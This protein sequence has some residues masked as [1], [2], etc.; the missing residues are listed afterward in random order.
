MFGAKRFF[1][2][3]T[4]VILGISIPFPRITRAQTPTQLIINYP[5]LQELDGALQLGLYFTLTDAGG[6]VVQDARIQSAR[7]QL[8]DGEIAENVPV[9]QPTT[10]FYIALVLDAS[11]SMSGAAESMRQ[12]AIRAINNAPEE[13][14]FAVVRFN[15]NID[16]LQP[17]T[18]DRNR[19]INA[20]GEVQ[21]VNK[22][23]T[24]LYDAAYTAIRMMSEAPQGRR[25]I[26]L[27]TDGQDEVLGG[28]PCSQHIFND[29]VLY[30]NQPDA[31]VPI[32]TIGLSTNEQRINVAELRSM[33]AQTGGL[34]AIGG[35]GELNT[36]F[37]DIMDALKSQ[38]LA[39]GQFYPSAGMHTA[40][41][42][43]VLED[44][45]LLSAVT[46][47]NVPRDYT[48]P[49]TPTLTPTPIRVKL[50]ILSVTA[51]IAQDRIAVEVVV[52]GEQA[53]SEYRFDFFDANTNQLL[54]RVILPAPL[55][56]PVSIPASK[57]DGKV[58]LE[59]RALDAQ[60][61]IISWPDE[62]DK[63]VDKVSYTF[64]YV[65]PTP[66]PTHAPATAIPVGVTLNSIGYDQASDTVTL[67]LE[68]NA[69]EQIAQLKVSVLD[70]ETNLRV[71]VYTL[72][73]SDTLQIKAENLKPEGEY[74]IYIIAQ[75][76][77][78][79]NLARS[80]TVNF[81]YTPLLT[82][83]PTPSPTSTRTPT[84][85]PVTI[86]IDGITI[87][88]NANEIVIALREV[89]D[90]RIDSYELQ[91]RDKNGLVVGE[92]VHTPPPFEI[93][94][95]LENFAP[96][97]YSAYLRALGPQGA[98]LTEASPLNFAYN[99]PP[100]LT[101]TLTLTPSPTFTPT[102]RPGL[103]Q[104]VTHAVHDNP[105]LTLVVVV[106]AFILLL[107]LFL[108][109]RPR[110][111]QQVGTAFLAEQTGF[112]EMPSGQSAP[113]APAGEGAAPETSVEPQPTNVYGIGELLGAALELRHSPAMERLGTRVTVAD[114][115][116]RIGR[117][118]KGQ[119]DA[120]SL[121]EDTSVSR[122][123]AQITYEGGRFYL[124]DLGSS[125]GTRVDGVRL[126]PDTPH[127][128]HNGAQ[129]VFGKHTEATFWQEEEG[130]G[131]A[132]DV[133]FADDNDLDKTD[134]YPQDL[135]PP[136]FQDGPPESPDATA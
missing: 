111:G 86:G 31:R 51:D 58:R 101:P 108:L 64:A 8:D 40:T 48:S 88:E 72:P 91:L 80:N 20:I 121:D 34:S 56:S 104:R 92:Y 18:D 27:F 110:K 118:M 93:R 109:L 65:R 102:P 69:T 103:P 105:A 96:G 75:S 62:R 128:L 122:R 106:V 100:T 63:A 17:F 136:R 116:F 97:E 131:D 67:D 87:D 9:E 44:G 74:A 39:S 10:P 81:V 47:F 52:N 15:Q 23:G 24:C 29:V 120:L 14:R 130:D 73:P 60:G 126:T 123:H 59:L 54:D 83:T 26:I 7:I 5:E 66:T 37:Q 38:W 135:Q 25:A 99:P 76:A 70:A 3:L 55:S 12:A 115:P 119:P 35:Q 117:G 113:S 19:A 45:S 33:A 114:V 124:T 132:T 13:A 112:Y 127:P 107:A 28:D 78:G 71:N 43:V 84:P 125:N 95:P 133:Y 134:Y 36:L 46:S 41:L 21:P 68:M 4:I 50:E 79:Q 11:G 30:A 49:I 1:W 129:I 89:A 61:N 42:T 90:A 77:T 82:P 57:L 2:L 6:R 22:S 32:H 53:I 16:I 98:L 94:V 85:A